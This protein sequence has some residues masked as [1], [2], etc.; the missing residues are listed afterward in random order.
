MSYFPTGQIPT[1]NLVSS[2]VFSLGDI[3]PSCEVMWTEGRLTFSY[4]KYLV[5]NLWS[6]SWIPFCEIG[7]PWVLLMKITI[8]SNYSPSLSYIKLFLNIMNLLI[9]LFL[10][11]IS[12]CQPILPYSEPSLIVFLTH[13]SHEL[14]WPTSNITDLR[15]VPAPW[16]FRP[17][18]RTWWMGRP[19]SML[20]SPWPD[21]GCG[22]WRCYMIN[23]KWRYYGDT[24]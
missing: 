3:N 1:E 15:Q 22:L 20:G 10:T 7:L 6:T 13:L 23:D 24:W 4:V 21:A 2:T 19:S 11:I 12:P 9:H 17:R 18:R 16:A 14:H 8:D 5:Q